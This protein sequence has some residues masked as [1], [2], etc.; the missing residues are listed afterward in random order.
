MDSDDENVEDPDQVS[1]GI[2]RKPSEMDE[3]PSGS[4]A[5]MNVANLQKYAR[6]KRVD[7]SSCETR[8]DM[9]KACA[10]ELFG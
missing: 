7:L 5:T 10:P 6:I 3:L 8:M 2:A 4:V 9:I 1:S